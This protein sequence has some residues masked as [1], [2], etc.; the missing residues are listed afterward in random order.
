MGRN[1]DGLRPIGVLP[2]AEAFT[3]VG[4]VMGVK[5]QKCLHRFCSGEGRLAVRSALADDRNGA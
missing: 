4:T 5:A 1:P 2:P 3:L